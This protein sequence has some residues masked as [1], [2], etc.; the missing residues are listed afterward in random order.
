VD[1]MAKNPRG[2]HRGPKTK[3]VPRT[4]VEVGGPLIEDLP[5]DDSVNAGD[6]DDQGEDEQ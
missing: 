5:P 6:E 3:R 1:N 2:H 4:A